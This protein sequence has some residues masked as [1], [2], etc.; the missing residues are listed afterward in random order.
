M[1]ERIA[2]LKTYGEAPKKRPCACPIW[3]CF[4]KRMA[5]GVVSTGKAATRTRSVQLRLKERPPDRDK[6]RSVP[7]HHN[8]AKTRAHNTE[9]GP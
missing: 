2:C 4:V 6:D 8:L 9:Y 7:A 1:Q 5:K 3:G